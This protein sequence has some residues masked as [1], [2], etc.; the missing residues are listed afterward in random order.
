MLNFEIGLRNLLS[1]HCSV[2]LTIVNVKVKFQKL[3]TLK[4]T[5]NDYN[6]LDKAP[7]GIGRE[8]QVC[9]PRTSR[10]RC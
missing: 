8:A 1:Q 2:N 3:R 6:S 4:E 10:R 7:F 5:T 9:G